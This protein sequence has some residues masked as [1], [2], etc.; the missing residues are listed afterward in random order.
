[1]IHFFPKCISKKRQV[2]R[3]VAVLFA[4]LFFAFQLTL[5][6]QEASSPLPNSSALQLDPSN[7]PDSVIQ[8]FFPTVE[9]QTGQPAPTS[10][11]RNGDELSY[12][13]YFNQTTRNEEEEAAEWAAPHRPQLTPPVGL[14]SDLLSNYGVRFDPVSNSAWH[15]FS[16]G[17]KGF[18]LPFENRLAPRRYG[19]SYTLAS[20]QTQMYLLGNI[21]NQTF[22][23]YGY[24]V[25]G[26]RNADKLMFR[27]SMYLLQ[28]S[29]NTTYTPDY[30]YRN[31]P[32]SVDPN[33]P[34]NYDHWIAPDLSKLSR[35]P[36]PNGPS[37]KGDIFILEQPDGTEITYY[38]ETLDSTVAL[39]EAFGFFFPRTIRSPGGQTTTIHYQALQRRAL[40]DSD[41]MPDLVDSYVYSYI[42]DPYG[43]EIHFTYFT[44]EDSIQLQGYLK[45]IDLLE[46]STSE[47]RRLA[48]FAYRVYPFLTPQGKE[49]TGIVLSKYTDAQG[50]ETL[51]DIH[52]V[53]SIADEE[54][55]VTLPS[56]FSISALHRPAHGGEVIGQ[57]PDA[58]F[59]SQIIALK[60]EHGAPKL[61]I[62]SALAAYIPR[63]QAPPEYPEE[64]DQYTGLGIRDV[65]LWERLEDNQ[66]WE[67]RGYTKLAAYMALP[68]S[69]GAGTHIY[70]YG[71][72]CDF[73]PQ[74]QLAG[75]V[76]KSLDIYYPK[77]EGPLFS[78]P[79][80]SIGGNAILT[81]HRFDL[82]GLWGTHITDPPPGECERFINTYFNTHTARITPRL[83]ESTQEIYLETP[84]NPKGVLKKKTLTEYE[85]TFNRVYPFTSQILGH[86]DGAILL[87][88][89]MISKAWDM[90]AN[91]IS[92]SRIVTEFDYGNLSVK[93][94]VFPPGAQVY[95]AP[96]VMPI[97]LGTEQ[98][99]FDGSS[100]VSHKKVDYTYDD[101]L[102]PSHKTRADRYTDPTTIVSTHQ[103]WNPPLSTPQPFNAGGLLKMSYTGSDPETATE[104]I[105]RKYGRPEQVQEPLAPLSSTNIDLSGW[106]RSRLNRGVYSEMEY[107]NLGRVI[108]QATPNANQAP[109]IF[110][111]WQPG[112]IERINTEAMG[113]WQTPRKVIVTRQD[114]RGRDVEQT[115]QIL[116]GLQIQT[117][118]EYDEL[119]MLI[120]AQNPLGGNEKVTARDVLRRPLRSEISDENGTI[121]RSVAIA[122]ENLNDGGQLITET[123]TEM[124]A[125][126]PSVV[127]Q[128]QTDFFGRTISTSVNR[129]QFYPNL[130][131]PQYSGG[132]H[133]QFVY[134]FDP[135]TGYTTKTIH[136]YGLEDGR[137]RVEVTDMLDRP[138]SVTDPE[139]GGG[140]MFYEY[141][142]RDLLAY[143]TYPDD[144][145]YQYIYDEAGRLSETR[146][147]TQVDPDCYDLLL[148][149]ELYHATY[150]FTQERI[151]RVGDG[152]RTSTSA[153]DPDLL[154][155]PREFSFKPSEPPA[156]S[157]LLSREILGATW[158][159]SW[160]ALP[161]SAPMAVEYVLELKPEAE[162]RQ[163]LYFPDIRINHPNNNEVT[164]TLDRDRLAV[165]LN[166]Q[167]L[168]H[169]H[170]GFW[171][172]DLQEGDLHGSLLDPSKSY[173]FRVVAV[174]SFFNATRPSSWQG[175]MADLLVDNLDVVLS[176][177]GS[178]AD[179]DLRVINAGTRMSEP[180]ETR[181][182]LSETFELTEDAQLLAAFNT[183][184]LEPGFA[185]WHAL[186]A[187]PVGGYAYVIVSADHGNFTVELNENNNTARELLGYMGNPQPDKP[188]LNVE[189]L[190]YSYVYIGGSG[191]YDT[192]ATYSVLNNSQIPT[193]YQAG[194]AGQTTTKLY[195][196]PDNL[197]SEDDAFLAATETAALEPGDREVQTT[198]IG[199]NTQPAP[200]HQTRLLAH[201]NAGLDEEPRIDEGANHFN[202]VAAVELPQPETIGPNLK[203]VNLVHEGV[204]G[205]PGTGQIRVSYTVLNSGVWPANP[206]MT[207]FYVSRDPQFDPALDTRL[208][209]L[210]GGDTQVM[211]Q[212]Y[213]SWEDRLQQS[214]TLLLPD[215]FLSDQNYL[216]VVADVEEE[217][218]E[219]NEDDNWMSH[220]FQG[221][222]D[223]TVEQV[224]YD[225][226]SGVYTFAV[227]NL[228]L[229]TSPPTV[230]QLFI[231]FEDSY[232]PLRSV[233]LVQFQVPALAEGEMA[234]LTTGDGWAPPASNRTQYL[235]SVVDPENLVNER[236]ENNNVSAQPVVIEPQGLPQDQPDLTPGLWGFTDQIW[237]QPALLNGPDI[238]ISQ[239]HGWLKS[240]RGNFA[241]SV[242]YRLRVAVDEPV[243]VRIFI[244]LSDDP[245]F[246]GNEIFEHVSFL[247]EEDIDQIYAKGGG[248]NPPDYIM[249]RA[250]LV[251]GEASAINNTVYTQFSL[252]EVMAVHSVFNQSAVSCGPSTVGV[253][254]SRDNLPQISPG[255]DLISLYR[256]QPFPFAGEQPGHMIAYDGSFMNLFHPYQGWYMKVAVDLEN[257][258]SEADETNNVLVA[259]PDPDHY[260]GPYLPPGLEP[261]PDP[262][263]GGTVFAQ[264][265]NKPGA[266][267]QGIPDYAVRVE[268]WREEPGQPGMVQLNY[269]IENR[270]ATPLNIHNLSVFLSADLGLGADAK[271]G[272]RLLFSSALA[273]DARGDKSIPTLAPA[274][275]ESDQISHLARIPQSWMGSQ[276]KLI[277][278]ANAQVF[279]GDSS[280]GEI[281]YPEAIRL[282]FN[283]G[284]SVNLGYVE[285]ALLGQE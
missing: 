133:T 213:P 150:G 92:D 199:A 131:G 140:S 200:L 146:K 169:P 49:R 244:G 232:H 186:A 53:G 38:G 141:N 33:N 230:A 243:N 214:A 121:L 64:V 58:D 90:N 135:T 109:H 19:A 23:G 69:L 282:I 155:R 72:D 234:I 148:S 201:V 159:C 198:W 79:N 224:N 11:V 13:Q 258:I 48:S 181:V 215:N 54:E 262:G 26:N 193:N 117:C 73:Y 189:E 56:G 75:L 242:R 18:T 7:L 115:S 65:F 152:T 237:P 5:Y 228:D 102:L 35:I 52:P 36:N 20:W 91:Q 235:F 227:R 211:G 66:D 21:P 95:N 207:G 122:Y 212:I 196:S 50:F 280:A 28:G 187:Q 154:G 180:G 162:T 163:S 81:N 101:P 275:G 60:D 157:P 22:M 143:V 134:D 139:Y 127:K 124:G 78:E 166:A 161:D 156:W 264:D 30:L 236:N 171:L 178:M 83:R 153:L 67:L 229:L 272:D 190:V 239:V 249:V 94:L 253:F 17:I 151:S 182:Y 105:S 70:Q 85:Y 219:N 223:L 241:S 188:D 123:H 10:H 216:I 104:V 158:L 210:I 257:E 114:I 164:F 126:G 46:P 209:M 111:Y 222:S 82:V 204:T 59:S 116:P 183:P 284:T 145:K 245:V 285:P 221:F 165:A 14:A 3:Q 2:K 29:H 250:E 274:F 268:S 98:K 252:P 167:L 195:F 263:P 118:M 273:G 34:V 44:A 226:N 130:S 4:F 129:P 267:G 40:T 192:Y 97:H 96:Y 112:A 84:G 51:F 220:T 106:E 41:F 231:D 68:E 206:S 63:S 218:A 27:P 185:A 246:E 160:T 144:T 80:G 179:M 276:Y 42:Q 281:V 136:P 74:G 172:D 128:T 16:I 103:I 208:V 86:T 12:S 168:N 25:A 278:M 191:Q 88:W 100:Q 177:S 107:D 256:T 45:Q 261:L 57:V 247:A 194:N 149:S 260:A 240:G 39:G 205:G 55:L 202:N 173:H 9:P 265:H 119:D 61:V 225:V 113:D 93:G 270:T 87:P 15:G 132:G 8:T 31:G 37:V 1:M 175:D 176:P 283:T 76:K 217:V 120:Q 47:T 279:G 110:N 170:H 137:V 125:A 277:F 197:V 255:D 6:C 147:R 77:G 138:V 266:R 174:N 269:R 254:M 108:S 142:D 99:M 184:A 71:G 271:S 62:S 233:G 203:V 238:E 251:P 32:Q 248:P 89:R 24:L 43:R 259:D